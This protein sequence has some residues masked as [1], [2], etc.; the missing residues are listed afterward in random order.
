MNFHRPVIILSHHSFL[1]LFGNPPE[2]RERREKMRT[3]FVS[4]DATLSNNQ[5]NNKNTKKKNCYL[6]SRAKNIFHSV[7]FSNHRCQH[8]AICVEDTWD[9]FYST[10]SL[11]LVT[12]V[13]KIH[14]QLLRLHPPPHPICF[15]GKR[16]NEKKKKRRRK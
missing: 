13:D 16:E 1:K 6:R 8:S 15:F 9:T 3:K 10:C 4:G 5:K 12:H 7:R 11:F 2:K 14:G